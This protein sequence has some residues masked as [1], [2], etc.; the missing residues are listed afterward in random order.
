MR[1]WRQNTV[2]RDPNPVWEEKVKEGYLSTNRFEG[3]KIFRP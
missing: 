1:E 3:C 2:W